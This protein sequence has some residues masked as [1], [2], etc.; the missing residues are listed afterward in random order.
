MRPKTSLLPV[1]KNSILIRSHSNGQGERRTALRLTLSCSRKSLRTVP[2]MA[3]AAT[4]LRPATT[5][6]KVIPYPYTSA[7]P[8]AS[9]PSDLED[10]LSLSSFNLREKL[11]HAKHDLP[12]VLFDFLSDRFGPIGGGGARTS[13]E[14]PL[15]T[16]RRVDS[17]DDVPRTDNGTL[18]DSEAL[19][20]AET[21]TTTETTTSATTTTT[22]NTTPAPETTKMPDRSPLAERQNLHLTPPFVQT[23]RQPPLPQV[24]PVSTDSRKEHQD[25]YGD[26]DDYY[27]DEYYEG[28]EENMLGAN[29]IDDGA[30]LMYFSRER[31]QYK[32]PQD[33]NSLGPPVPL[34][35]LKRKKNGLNRVEV[36]T[37]KANQKLAISL[38][39]LAVP[40][41]VRVFLRVILITTLN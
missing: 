36:G 2:D 23:D 15:S 22:K 38:P 30:A 28:G 39:H 19:S 5:T 13:F 29:D 16:T 12:A 32:T 4:T 17:G 6:G 35:S 7:T 1:D 33:E 24:W 27:Y 11:E 18:G 21:K 25:Y 40:V 14:E 41:P 8:S 3:Q 34:Y 9:T 37:V 31:L 10:Q 20:M 26:K